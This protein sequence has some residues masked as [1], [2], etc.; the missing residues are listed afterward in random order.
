VDGFAFINNM[1]DMKGKPGWLTAFGRP[2]LSIGEAFDN[3]LIL[4]NTFWDGGPSMI[5]NSFNVSD[6]VVKNNL[7]GPNTTGGDLNEFGFSM[8]YN[9]YDLNRPLSYG[10]GPNS[11][12]TNPSRAIPT[13]TPL[14]LNVM[15][16]S[17]S[18]GLD[19][20]GNFR[21][22]PISPAIDQGTTESGIKY[23]LD[24]KLRDSRPD[25]GAYER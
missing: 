1:V 17:F 18:T 9:L 4:H 19:Y 21:L 22:S 7:F 15:I 24:W 12:L 5:N 20:Y 10:R 6:F 16:Q 13:L 14:F 8:D 11:L 3:V 23:D 25:M 2:G